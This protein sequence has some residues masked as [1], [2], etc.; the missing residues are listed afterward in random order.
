MGRKSEQTTEYILS[1]AAKYFA[2]VG[3]DGARVDELA[4]QVGVNKATL[5]YQIGSKKELYA[6]VLQR[7][8]SGCVSMVQQ[9]VAYEQSAEAKIKALIEA[10]TEGTMHN[11]YTG[12]VMLR[13]IASGGAHLPQSAE[14]AM[15]ELLTLLQQIMQQGIAE[16]CFR[17]ANPF[18][19]HM[20]IVG[21]VFIY[22]ANEPIRQRSAERKPAEKNPLHFLNSKQAADVISDLILAAIRLPK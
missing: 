2:E 17:E 18:F 20:M 8:L 10:F 22:Q 5:Y 15:G 19:V 21:T 11:R 16:Q 7:V 4:K 14:M 3:Y 13:E 6:A 1:S 12:P 9:R